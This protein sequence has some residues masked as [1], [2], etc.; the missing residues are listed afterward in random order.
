MD[1]VYFAFA[2]CGYVQFLF[3]SEMRHAILVV[4]T[5]TKTIPSLLLP[6]TGQNA[7]RI[8]A[9]DCMES[10]KRST[11]LFTQS[12]GDVMHGIICCRSFNPVRNHNSG[13]P[14]LLKWLT[15][16]IRTSVSGDWRT[17]RLSVLAAYFACNIIQAPVVQT[18]DSAIHRINHYPADKYYGN[19]LRYPLDNDL[20]GG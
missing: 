19:Q 20:S 2:G 10:R 12:M 9:R 7:G 15:L 8:T 3:L 18:S 14:K 13:H 17:S 4:S 6:D 5:T 11:K 16:W 1:V